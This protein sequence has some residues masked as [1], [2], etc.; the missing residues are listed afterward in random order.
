MDTLEQLH[1]LDRIEANTIRTRTCWLWHGTL[2]KDGYAV[3]DVNQ[4]QWRVARLV[5]ILQTGD[6]DVI[7]GKEVDHL[8]SVRN[9]VRPEHLEPV[10]VAQ[11][12]LRKT[13]QRASARR[14]HVLLKP[15]S[16]AAQRW[17]RRSPQIPI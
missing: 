17:A 8:C 2:D 1:L 13:G 6:P 15:G 4:K 7:Q 5:M 10:T 12:R 14:P 9:C 3:L 11:N 16:V